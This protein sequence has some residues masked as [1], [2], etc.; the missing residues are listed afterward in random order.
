VNFGN[1][2]QKELFLLETHASSIVELDLSNHPLQEADIM[3]TLKKL[4][5]LKV[6]K[7][8]NTSINSEQLKGLAH[9]KKLEVLNLFGNP[10]TDDVAGELLQSP[11]LKR[12]YL[13]KTQL[14]EAAIHQLTR[15]MK[16]TQFLGNNLQLIKQD[17]NINKK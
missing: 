5:N 11:N 15:S 1:I 17:S 10:L 9:L 4:K 8:G 6:L 13:W 12:V 3:S 2:G 16:A 14:S 7:L